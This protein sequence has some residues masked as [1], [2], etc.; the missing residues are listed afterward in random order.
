MHTVAAI[1][2]PGRRKRLPRLRGLRTAAA[3][4]AFWVAWFGLT[5]GFE[6]IRTF[7]D[8]VAPA[9]SLAG[10]EGALFGTWPTLA[11]Q[12]AFFGA[13]TRSFDQ[14]WWIM[15]GL[16]FG[17]P[18]ACGCVVMVRARHLLPEFLAWQVVAMYVSAV[19]YVAMP[20]EPPWMEPGV[21]RILYERS[22]YGESTVD[23]NPLAAFPS[24]HAAL[25]ACITVFYLLRGG[26]RLRM[27]AWPVA[28]Y[29]LLVGFAVVYL[30]EHWVLDV[31]G[32]FALAGVVAVIF[33]NAR[34]RRAY[35]RIPGD[36]V[37]KTG[38]FC[39]WLLPAPAENGRRTPVPATD[40][41]LRQAA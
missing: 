21:H 10:V 20:V 40:M 4:A 12:D 35:A 26:L 23:P 17:M 6:L 32:G 18:L 24:L 1:P 34:L 9:R 27:F 3:F 33:G 36:P 8:E 41:P 7:A 5:L 30:G 11:L 16:W 22:F 19:A 31:L 15:H 25:P 2:Q 28:A 38:R 37:A 13:G 29:S 39:D 14:V